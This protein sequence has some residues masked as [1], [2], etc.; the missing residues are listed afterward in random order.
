MDL[1]ELKVFQTVAKT[2]SIS[3]AARELNYAQSNISTK[4]KQLEDHFKTNL[5]YRHNKGITLTNKGQLLLEYSE[6]ILNLIDETKNAVMDNDVPRGPLHI[7]CLETLATTYLPQLISTYH[8]NYPHVDLAIKTDITFK[9]IEDVLNYK[10]DGAFIAG[11]INHPDL[12]QKTIKEEQLVL[13]TDT[14]H[15]T[16]SSIKDIQTK[17]LLVFPTGC[18]YRKTLEQWLDNEG[19]T[20]NKIMEFDTM[21]AII[22]CVCSGLGISLLPFPVVKKYIDSGV[23]KYHSIKEPYNKAPIVF[24]YRKD[25][26]IP[27]ALI[28]FINTFHTNP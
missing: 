14:L 22:S 7:G 4:I 13:I 15:P 23:L 21:S 5:F 12:E 11:E 27:K 19:I 20:P 24:I 17:T 6:K 1:Q 8:K 16:M 26:F 28:E 18:T 10:I 3:Q 9:N 25:K 2:G